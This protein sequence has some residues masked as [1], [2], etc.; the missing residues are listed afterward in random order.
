MKHFGDFGARA[1]NGR[2]IFGFHAQLLHP[3][4]DC[5]NGIASGDNK[6]FGLIA[7]DKCCQNFEFI[8]LGRIPSSA[9]I[10]ESI[11]AKVAS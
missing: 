6:V 10:S 2:Q 4:P 5:L 11:R 3:E 7:L 8:T 9:S 1:D